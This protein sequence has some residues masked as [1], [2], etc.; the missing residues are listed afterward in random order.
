MGR[1]PRL[2]I[3]VFLPLVAGLALGANTPSAQAH[4]WLVKSKPSS[5]EVV[6]SGPVEVLLWFSE[7]I[8]IQFSQV[9][10]VNSS[11]QR[12][13]NNDFHTHST[14]AQPGIT[15]Q[16]G[17][18]DGT[19]TV[20]WD[21]LSAVDG[22]RTKGSF[23]YYVGAPDVAPPA[24][25]GGA[26]VSL[27]SGP[28]KWLEVVVRWLN[29]A[30][31]ALLIGAAAAPFLL[32]PAGF[33]K[34]AEDSDEDEAAE[35]ASVALVRV[36]ALGAAL[37]VVIGSV[38]LLWLQA[39]AA[40]GSATA[41]SALG[42]VLTNTRFGDIWFVRI[43]LAGAALLFSM[44]VF[45]GDSAPW[46]QPIW[47]PQ[48]T[49][50]AA[51]LLAAL[52]IPITT[53]LNSHAAAA[54][55]SNL[56]T[57]VDWV[58]LV[59]AGVWIGGL[60]Q[61]LLAAALVAPYV[62]DRAG[63]LGALVRRFSLIALPSVTVIVATGAVQSIS[64]LGGVKD[65]VHSDYGYTLLV[66]L[67]LLAPLMGLGAINLLIIGPRFARLARERA[68][69][70][71]ASFL[72]WEGRFRLA[73]LAEI[74]LAVGILAATAVLTNTAPPLGSASADLQGQITRNA[75]GQALGSVVADD[76]QV[77]A[78][79][80]PGQP[81]VNEIN[82]LINDLNGDWRDVERVL[83]RIKSLD[84]DIGESE[85]EGRPIHPP[86]HFIATTSQI[87]LPGKWQLTVIVRREGLF[88]TRAEIPITISAPAI[89]TASIP[90]GATTTP[91]PSPGP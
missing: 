39:W 79:V 88:D 1:L 77:T 25:G 85:E 14:K 67:V 60:V 26:S 28:P 5:G 27:S 42:D 71:L 13:D 72:P 23:S 74:A 19:Y 4:A 62:S 76:L 3:L 50:W 40:G 36:S 59:A 81:G 21:V 64:R 9:E 24:D 73:L 41:S 83:V 16:L 22:H 70:I 82:V 34:L 46:W 47:A 6:Q 80:D 45:R 52:A 87:S 78:W 54:D 48:N 31:M 33:D 57:L 68:K 44:L 66:K 30:A 58:H 18:P 51:L 17:V 89:P 12:V 37:L 56:E 91:S 69:D 61:L 29:F 49:M 20:I 63:L 86:V 90:A 2:S 10:V 11:G 38:L 53:S 35:L 75:S 84:R 65:L 43:A 7:D 55:T 8:E 32:L 15:M